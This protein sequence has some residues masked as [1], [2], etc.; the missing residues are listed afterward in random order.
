MTYASWDL[1]FEKINY[2]L[3]VLN[4]LTGA[5]KY[6]GKFNAE[7]VEIIERIMKK[8]NLNANQ[9]VRR[10]VM[11]AIQ[12][13]EYEDLLQKN[14][15]VLKF[16][17]NYIEYFEK[18]LEKPSEAKRLEKALKKIGNDAIAKAE[19]RSLEIDNDMSKL[20]TEKKPGRP[21]IKKKRGRPKKR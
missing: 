13:A 4:L 21:K 15:K 14:P 11:L 7:E 1:L 9:F 17:K 2:Y 8:Y 3:G 18:L 6:Q 16:F 5:K 12:R 19:K 10:S 20:L